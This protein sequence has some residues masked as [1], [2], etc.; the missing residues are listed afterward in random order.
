LNVRPLAIAGSQ[1]TTY[2]P[3]I[4]RRRHGF[5]SAPAS[6]GTRTPQDKLWPASLVFN[7]KYV[8]QT[9]GRCSFA[10]IVRSTMPGAHAGLLLRSNTL[11]RDAGSKQ[12]RRPKRHRSTSRRSAV[13][14]RHHDTHPAC[15]ALGS[16]QRPMSSC[17]R[18]EIA[19]SG[20]SATIAGFHRVSTAP[21]H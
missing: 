2:R 9:F 8:A 15:S 11:E 6:G 16:S 12:S 7:F 3:A 13:H 17:A 21:V 19:K 18:G 10:R 20:P 5:R 1:N 4:A 14:E